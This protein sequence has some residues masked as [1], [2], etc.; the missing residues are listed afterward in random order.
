MKG[1][2]AT[3]R[4]DYLV[5][6][7]VFGVKEPC[8]IRVPFP[9]LD[10]MGMLTACIFLHGTWRPGIHGRYVKFDTARSTTSGFSNMY[11]S[12]VDSL[13]MYIAIGEQENLQMSSCPTRSE[14]YERFHKGTRYRMGLET[15]QDYAMTP[16]SLSAI[17][18]VLEEA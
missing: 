1:N 4:R 8:P 6:Q 9:L 16:R 17:L 5:A 11:R 13:G 14:F 3:L 7:E 10:N 15:K 12:G 2:L 18:E